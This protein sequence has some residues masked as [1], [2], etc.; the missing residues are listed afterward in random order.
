MKPGTD[1]FDNTSL[2]R[3]T[4]A[5]IAVKIISPA[6]MLVAVVAIAHSRSP[7]V[8]G[9]Y[10][11]L[12]LLVQLA[13][14]LKCL[15]LS[16]LVTR[17]TAR[18]PKGA[19]QWWH[20]LVRIGNWGTLFVA[21]LLLGAVAISSGG[22]VP[23]SVLLAFVALL[24]GLWASSYSVAN[25]ALFFGLGRVSSLAVVTAI[26]CTTR[27]V[28]SIAALYLLQISVVGLVC[29]YSLTR[30]LSACVGG[31]LRRKLSLPDSPYDKTFTTRLLRE[32]MPF[33]AVFVFPLVLF[34]IDV[35]VLGLAGTPQEVGIYS[36]ASRLFTLALLIPDAAMATLFASYSHATAVGSA[37]FR[38]LVLRSCGAMVAFSTLMGVAA[39]LIA[40]FAI[41]LFFGKQFQESASLFKLLI[42]A[43]PLFAFSRSV[44]DALVALDK[45]T[46]TASLVVATT[47]LSLG[48]YFFLVPRLHGRG[49]ALG[50]LCSASLL[51]LLSAIVFWRIE[52]MPLYQLVFPLVPATA[53]MF[54]ILLHSKD[55]VIDGVLVA[56]AAV[57][58]LILVQSLTRDRATANPSVTAD[59]ERSR[60]WTYQ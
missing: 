44:G 42:W 15:G 57:S 58:A 3:N 36:A 48:F 35:L 19:P 14:L 1:N 51:A 24:P 13:E 50:F 27:A 32:A 18:G 54:V 60:E 22:R 2:L 56:V 45:Q 30:I 17:E 21:P 7:A 43:L 8:L 9:Q 12:V 52:P 41:R 23:A 55:L 25:E 5:A 10:T 40:P 33:L 53:A 49:A 29:I 4:L 47:I 59:N 28:I 20:S 38:T 39:Y 46:A 34:R 6:S 11:F 16:A 26:E 31:I 37:A